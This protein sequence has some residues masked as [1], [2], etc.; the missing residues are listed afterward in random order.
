MPQQIIQLT[1][2]SSGDATQ[3]TEAFTGFVESIEIDYAADAD[4]GTDVTVVEAQG[5]GRTLV[6]LANNKT[7][8]IIYPVVESTTNAGASLGTA[9]FR[10][11][12]IEG[13]KLTFTV[14]EGT[15]GKVVTM[16]VIVSH[17][18]V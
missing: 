9:Q 11:F 16:T 13:S 18:R 4:A 14:D 7:D 17:H 15:S 10:P 6:N 1:T 2:D 5:L 12:W 3:D 8:K